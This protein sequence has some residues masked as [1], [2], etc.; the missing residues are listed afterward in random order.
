MRLPGPAGRA[1]QRARARRRE[2]SGAGKA[3]PSREEHMKQSRREATSPPRPWTARPGGKGAAQRP[4]A[5]A[6]ARPTPRP[7]PVR[8]R[9][10]IDRGDRHR[11]HQ[12]LLLHRA[13]REPSRASSASATRS[14]AACAAARSSISTRPAPRSAA[15]CMPPRR[16][17]AS[18][19]DRAVV[20][21]SGGYRRLAHR[22]DRD[23]RRPARDQ[24]RRHAP[25]A[26]ARLCDARRA[27]IARSS[28]RSR[29]ASRSTTAAASSI[30]AA[31]SASGSAST[32]T[33]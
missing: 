13:G 25:G 16:W 11:H 28:I 21:L 5:A 17:P 32:C 7:A 23:R 30:R 26:G 3:A 2:G 31:W 15:R 6:P 27:A 10:S 18:T 20:N 9:G 8:P 19:I 4:A 29:S 24:R 1:G 22:Q 14:R 33:S 12:D